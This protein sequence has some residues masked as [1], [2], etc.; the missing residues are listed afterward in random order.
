MARLLVR[1]SRDS[2]LCTGQT[3]KLKLGD[4]FKV[5]KQITIKNRNSELEQE[6]RTHKTHSEISSRLINTCIN[7]AGALLTSSLDDL[8]WRGGVAGDAWL[9]RS[10]KTL[11]VRVPGVPRPLLSPPAPL[12]AT[13]RFC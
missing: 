7:F 11:L 10:G 5:K 6:S 1:F 13:P 2:R 4:R 12:P 8:S 3:T 9:S